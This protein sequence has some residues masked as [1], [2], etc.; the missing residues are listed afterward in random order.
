M[1]SLISKAVI[2][3]PHLVSLEPSCA[4]EESVEIRRQVAKEVMIWSNA[5]REDIQKRT[6]MTPLSIPHQS[7]LDSE[8]YR[9]GSQDICFFAL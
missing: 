1:R 2:A 3:T 7:Q 4:A 6:F 9:R 8:R 5:K